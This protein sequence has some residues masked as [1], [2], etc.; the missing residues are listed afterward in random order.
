MDLDLELY[1]DQLTQLVDKGNYE[2]AGALLAELPNP[3]IA[4]VLVELDIEAARRIMLGLPA[5]QQAS[6]FGYLRPANQAQMAAGM[7]RRQLAALFELMDHDERADLYNRLSDSE[8]WAVLPGL[9]HA[10]R[11][12]IRQLASYSEDTV[13]SIMTSAYV[14]LRPDQTA[15]QALDSIRLEA[16]DVET[17]Y[18][19]YVVESDRRLVGTISLRDLLLA[20]PSARLRNLM[21]KDVIRSRA[22]APK[23]EAARLIARYDILAV[24]VVN[25]DDQ[26]VGIVTHDDALDV[27]EDESTADQHRLG[28]VARLTTSLSESTI[29]SLY[30]TRV[31][32]LVILIFGNVFSGASIAHFEDLIA[33][34]VSLVFFL[35]LLIDSGGNAGSQSSTLMVRALATEDVRGRDWFR[36]L[37]KELLV[38]LLLGLTMAAAVSLLGFWRGGLSVALIV[39]IT[40]ILIVTVGSVIGMSLPFLL[41]RFKLDPASAS[42]PL[43]TT[44]CDGVGVLI[45]FNVASAVLNLPPTT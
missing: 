41:T 7:S 14:T 44:I 34:I 22:S 25:D 28:A 35:P 11:E 5:K 29:T 42:A 12:D 2:A 4:E 23:V 33:R 43:V 21:I 24:P 38:S 3:D 40:M 6:V 27:T 10:E 13:G 15:G 16:P 20:N 1:T 9:A 32:W 17:I 8:R 37:G 18:Q 19:S 30:R 36:L 26:M 45:Y 39:S 31:G